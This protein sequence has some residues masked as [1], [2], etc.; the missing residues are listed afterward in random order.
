MVRFRGTREELEAWRERGKAKDAERLAKALASVLHP[1]PPE[2]PAVP[3]AGAC[4]EGTL[5]AAIK[6]ILREFW[7]A[8]P[9]T[10]LVRCDR[11]RIDAALAGKGYPIPRNAAAGKA[12]AMAVTRARRKKATR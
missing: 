11:E 12:R 10:R 9:P 5:G 1:A 2:Q 7:P 4:R 3:H 8:G 6:Q